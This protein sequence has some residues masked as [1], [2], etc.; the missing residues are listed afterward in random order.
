[1]A[2]P[3]P[4]SPI[5][6]PNFSTG[7]LPDYVNRGS[8]ILHVPTKSTAQRAVTYAVL[9]ICDNPAYMRFQASLNVNQNTDDCRLV[10]AAAMSVSGIVPLTETTG[11]GR[12]AITDVTAMWTELIALIGQTSAFTS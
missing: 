10:Q 4:E 5:V 6:V 2:L 3:L 1:M 9:D 11:S 8:A 7:G 12:A